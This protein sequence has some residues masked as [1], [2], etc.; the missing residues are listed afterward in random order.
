MALNQNQFKIQPIRGERDMAFNG[1]V[2]S[3]QISVSDPNTSV[4]G[5]PLTMED[6]S[7]GVPKFI[8]TTAANGQI[9][10]FALYNIKDV[11]YAPGAR[12]E[13]AMAGS[14]M[15]MTA[16]AAI[17]RGAKLEVVISTTDPRVITNAG[18]NK[19]VGIALDKALAAGDLIRVYVVVPS[20]VQTI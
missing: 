2:I 8:Q 12:V 18:T 14:V 20:P 3:A 10:G 16:N 11:N 1:D 9:F 13:V 7:G 17:A 15:Y 19:V 6:S 5:H 4:P